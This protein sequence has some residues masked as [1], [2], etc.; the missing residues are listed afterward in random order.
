M[1]TSRLRRQEEG[2]IMLAALVMLVLMGIIGMAASSLIGAVSSMLLKLGVGIRI[3]AIKNDNGPAKCCCR[4]ALRKHVL[5]MTYLQRS[6][7]HSFQLPL[8]LENG[9][10]VFLGPENND[11]TLPHPR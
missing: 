6:L 9:Q 10:T 3:K 8:L 5:K 1:R 11:D 4:E 7:S 2:G